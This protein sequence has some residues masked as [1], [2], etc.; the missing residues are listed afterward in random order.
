MCVIHIRS[1]F[2]ITFDST[3]PYVSC[4]GFVLSSCITTTESTMRYASAEVH[5]DLAVNSLMYSAE[6]RRLNCCHLIDNRYLIEKIGMLLVIFLRSNKLR[7]ATPFGKSL[8]VRAAKSDAPT[9]LWH[10]HNRYKRQATM[11]FNDSKILAENRTQFQ[12]CR[13]IFLLMILWDRCHIFIDR[14]SVGRRYRLQHVEM[15][16]L[17]TSSHMAGNPRFADTL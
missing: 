10:S 7:G 12:C 13:K 4:K 5:F 1:F 16:C 6:Q 15:D 9:R 3:R 2:P 8:M 14:C 17:W 11:R